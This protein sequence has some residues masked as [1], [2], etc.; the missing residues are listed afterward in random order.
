MEILKNPYTAVTVVIACI[1]VLYLDNASS[2]FG[3][4]INRFSPCVQ[5]PAQSAPCYIGYDIALMVFVAVIGFVFFL[6][7]IFDLYKM[8]K[9]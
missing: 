9:G 5:N 4:F 3:K 8:F 6:I 1:V 7:L 2:F